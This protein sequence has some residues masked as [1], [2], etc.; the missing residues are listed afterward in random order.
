M[1]EVPPILNKGKVKPVT[2]SKC[3]ETAIFANAWMTMLKQSPI[4]TIAANGL[5]H[6]VTNRVHLKSNV[7]YKNITT[8]PPIIPTSSHIIA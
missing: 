1:R 5:G 6:L 8:M 7:K 2:G 3:N 4:A